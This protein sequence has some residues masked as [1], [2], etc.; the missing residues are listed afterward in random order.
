MRK[1]EGEEKLYKREGSELW[2]LGLE[3][4]EKGNKN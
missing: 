1:D 2:L 3:L 4:K